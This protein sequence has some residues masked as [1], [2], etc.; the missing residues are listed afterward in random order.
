MSHL[1]EQDALRLAHDLY[2]LA[3][4]ARRLP[5][6][7]DD[8][9]QLA[10]NDGR[11]VVLKVVHVR[12]VREVIDLQCRA[13]AFLAE[14]A[15]ELDLPRV[16]PAADGQPLT[17]TSI[18]GVQRLVWMLSYVP[19]R[20]LAETN[21][22]S[23]ELLHSFGRLLGQIDAALFDFDHPAARRSAQVDS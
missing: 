14:R 10:S 3:S 22:H 23:P 6:E 16:C 13:L 11:T 5:G 21:P 12:Q 18:H 8:N 1:T 15:P 9:F 2:S 17:T 20:L 7:Y 4:T 19:G